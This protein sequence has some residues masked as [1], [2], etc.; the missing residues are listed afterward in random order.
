MPQ[1]SQE[2]RR[3]SRIPF[4]ARVVLEQ[5]DHQWQGN[6]L[7]ISLKGLLMVQYSAEHVD[8]T[9]PVVAQ[10]RLDGGATILMHGRVAHQEAEHLGLACESID[11]DSITHLRRLLELNTGDSHALER[12]LSELITG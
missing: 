11:I 6:L 5:G 4:D 3:F 9:R 2:R 7:D 8:P 10:V 12:E 1:H